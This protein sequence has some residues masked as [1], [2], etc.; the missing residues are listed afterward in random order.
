[1][2]LVSLCDVRAYLLE[3]SVDIDYPLQAAL[4]AAIAEAS[5]FAGFDLAAAYCSTSAPGDLKTAIVLLT[6]IHGCV[7]CS[8]DI[9]S[10]RGIA[11]KLML[12]YRVDT[13]P[14]GVD[15]SALSWR[16]ADAS[17]AKG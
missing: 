12:F 1:M 8:E 2:T 14:I 17:H 6:H 11:Q 10:R 3:L 4:A 13:N 9:E 16:L 7:R 15:S 5:G